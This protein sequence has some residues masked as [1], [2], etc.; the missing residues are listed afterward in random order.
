MITEAL[1]NLFFGLL[2][3]IFGLLPA[4]EFP[5][6]DEI[7][8]S[9]TTLADYVMKA[10]QFIPVNHI[11]IVTSAVIGLPIFKFMFFCVNWIIRRIA[12]VIP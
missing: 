8:S 9:I 2:N 1:L 10:N 4:L 6:D 7:A 11:F 12:D 3:T 5:F